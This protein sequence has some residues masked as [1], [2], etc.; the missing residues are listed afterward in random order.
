MT[1]FKDAR[2][3]DPASAAAWEGALETAR[4]EVEHEIYRRSTE[5]CEEPVLSGKYNEAGYQI[6]SLR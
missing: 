1:T 6:Y 4:A 3:R 5:G 2:E